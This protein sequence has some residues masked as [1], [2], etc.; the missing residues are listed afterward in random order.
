MSRDLRFKR[1]GCDCTN[2][3]LSGRPKVLSTCG[4]PNPS[5]VI[6][7]EAPG[8]NESL[9]E[10]KGRNEDS[11]E[12]SQKEKGPFIGS[13]AGILKQAF[14]QAGI[15]WHTVYRMNVINCRPE[16][17]KLDSEEAKDAIRCCKEGFEREL[18]ELK[19][20]GATVIVPVGNIALAALGVD[21]TISKSRG[22]VY[23]IE[24]FGGV[25]VPT[26]HPGFILHGAI[27]EEA[28]WVADLRKAR[29]LS[30]KKWTAPKEIFNLEPTLADVKKFVSAAIKN[31]SLVAGDI[32]TDGGFNPDY[33][34]ITMIGFATDGEHAIVIP[35][36][37][38][39]ENARKRY[40]SIDD[41]PVVKREIQRLFDNCDFMFQNA[42]FDVYQLAEKGLIVRHLVHDTMLLHHAI[43]PEL[44]HDLG[45]IVSIYGSTPYWK[46]ITKGSKARMIE[47]E[48]LPIRRYNARDCVTL[49]QC[50]PSMLEDLKDVGTER[51]YYDWSM[52]LVWPLIRMKQKGLEVDAKRLRQL[53]TDLEKEYK[54]LDSELR[55]L[56]N[57]PPQFNFDSNPQLQ[58][59][60]YG[61][62]PAGLE[63]KK[64]EK[65]E[66]DR[67]EKRNKTTK[68]YLELA[69]TISL[70]EQVKPLY[71][72]HASTNSCDAEAMLAIQQSASKRLEAMD[73]LKRKNGQ[74]DVERKDIER[75]LKFI[76]IFS[77]YSEVSKMLGT[78]TKYPIAKDGR[79]HGD[80]KIH[81]TATG[82]LSSANPNLQNQP[83][84]VRSIFIPDDGNVLIEADYSNLE[85]RVLAYM[86]EEPF[87]IKSFA[88]FDA[89]KGP[90][91][92]VMN[93][94]AFWGIEK[95]DP[96]WEKKYRVTK[97]V[98]FGSNYGGGLQ[99]LYKRAMA[100]V[101]GMALSFAR[102]S[103][104]VTGYF[105]K[106]VKYSGWQQSVRD[107]VTGRSKKEEKWG[108]LR[109]IAN[110][111]GRK[112]FFLGAM[113]EIEREALNTPIQGTAADIAGAAFIKLDSILLENPKWKASITCMVH[114]SILVECPKDKAK[115]VA[116][117]MRES[118]Q[119]EFKINGKVRSFP[120]DVKIGTNW[121]DMTEQE[122]E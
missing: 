94:K 21:G 16:G 12:F 58:F 32:E 76:E 88:D 122:E 8:E 92:H 36:Q 40:W 54:A 44:A 52:K 80:F 51:T 2:C 42:M 1:E 81:G 48:E 55:S 26:Y 23:S 20:M 91:I 27:R 107:T 86:T 67:S 6:L 41:E 90:S 25:A 9:A 31:K 19:K 116:A 39:G 34:S 46:D 62:L 71:R 108:G 114:D 47:Q 100:D 13:Y 79:V 15:M 77:R 121:Y 30:V 50:L 22:S 60:L 75:L 4:I 43:H 61:K 29:D 104:I 70:Y 56:L 59:L 38:G 66:I 11:R 102:F 98:I 37:R 101:P 69:S 74:H 73:F 63:K 105:A 99:G 18:Q 112:R 53:K 5:I 33:N 111:F 115:I 84:K 10:V 85:L 3:P 106:M 35:F 49:H 82:R 14:G 57:L 89:G 113:E 97:S 45:Y 28:I 17:N 103:E 120:V 7:G 95:D 117:A 72:T 118:M 68:K 119:Q 87:L 24:R 64:E 78:Y 109:W 110:A 93:C 83:K 65:D 96:T